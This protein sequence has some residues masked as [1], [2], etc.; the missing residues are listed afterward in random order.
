MT[1][2]FSLREGKLKSRIWKHWDKIEALMTDMFVTE[3]YVRRVDFDR[4]PE[5]ILI[6]F[7]M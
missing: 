3:Y 4:N 7:V 5:T 6:Y 1:M 2:A